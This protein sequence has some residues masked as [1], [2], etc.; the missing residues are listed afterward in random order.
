M[1]RR[2]MF[3]VLLL[4]G[5]GLAVT[6]SAGKVPVPKEIPVTVEFADRAGD[7]ILSD[8]SGPYINGTKG[9][10]AVIVPLGNLQLK[11]GTVRTFWLDFTDCDGELGSCSA[12]FDTGRRQGYMTTSCEIPLPS[13]VSGGDLQECNLNV[14]LTADPRGWFIRFGGY[15]GT[16]PASVKRDSPTSWT[17]KVP[18]GGIALLQSYLLKGRMVLTDHGKF[19]MP[20]QLTVTTLP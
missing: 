9:V 15:T 3:G 13:M 7:R 17:I 12:P 4:A 14:H 20:V 1:R 6:T 19:L 8:D 11:T 18:D 2:L 16:T 10:T 5:L